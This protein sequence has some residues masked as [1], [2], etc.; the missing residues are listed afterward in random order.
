[1]NVWTR[2]TAL[3]P[4]QFRCEGEL[5]GPTDTDGYSVTEPCPAM[6]SVTLWASWHA[7]VMRPLGRYCA[8]CVDDGENP[9]DPEVW[10]RLNAPTRGAGA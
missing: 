6:A 8:D 4:R 5:W 3:P 9:D 1:M 2:T 10:R 7:A